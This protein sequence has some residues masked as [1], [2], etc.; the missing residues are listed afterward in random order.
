MLEKPSISEET[1]KNILFKGFGLSNQTIHFLPLGADQNTAVYKAVTRDAKSYFVKLRFGELNFASIAIPRF[2][3]DSGLRQIIPPIPLVNNSLWLEEENFTVQVYPFVDGNHG[4][5]S[6][7]TAIQWQIFG[8]TIKKLHQTNL[9]NSLRAMVP[10][11]EYSTRFGE[12]LRN[13]IENIGSYS[14][15]DELDRKTVS[16]MTEKK[17]TILELIQRSE[18]LAQSL[19]KHPPEHVLCHGD[20]HG[21]NLLIGLEGDL[22]L[23][24]WDTLVFAPKERDLMFIGAGIGNSGY[25]PQEE[26]RLFYTG[27]GQ[28]EINPYA[29]AFY[30]YSR[31]VED[32]ALFFDQI[33]LADE[34]N[35]DRKQAFLYL[36]SNFYPGG[37][38]ERAILSDQTV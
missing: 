1:I 14:L 15:E 17:A 2:L 30:R 5:H 28:T 10:E 7:L 18:I 11:E 4:F 32:I 36:R 8:Q 27:Y 21:W 6:P 20:M 37:P 3:F 16:L 13:N 35:E 12:I 25:S 33:I 24:D 26:T 29:L 19:K 34:H 38:I 9:P 23:V 22:Y 31:I